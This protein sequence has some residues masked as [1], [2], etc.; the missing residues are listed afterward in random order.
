MHKVFLSL[1]PAYGCELGRLLHV[2]TAVVYLGIQ[3]VPY[4]ILS[5]QIARER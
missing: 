3:Y 4:V 1:V 2:P 5:D